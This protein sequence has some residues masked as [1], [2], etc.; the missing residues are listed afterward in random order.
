MPE[1]TE[2][3]VAANES[4]L[5]EI[6]AIAQ[7]LPGEELYVDGGPEVFSGGVWINQQLPRTAHR[8]ADEWVDNWRWLGEPGSGNQRSGITIARNPD[9]RLEAAVLNTG[10]IVWHAWQKRPDGDWSAWSSL[11]SP[12]PGAT[13]SGPTLATNKD[14]RLQLFTT[15]LRPEPA[16][17]YRTQKEPG[18]GPWEEW[19]SLGYPK[20]ERASTQAP[21]VA[22]NIDGR[23]ELFIASDTEIWHAWQKSPAGDWSSWSSLGPPGG[24]GWPVAACDKDGRLQV[25]V[26]SHT[27]TF[28]SSQHEPGRGPW[29]P[30]A[31][32]HPAPLFSEISKLA[33][34]A[35]ADGRL[36]LCALQCQSEQQSVE[37]LE[38]AHGG[39]SWPPQQA[40]NTTDIL[41]P[42]DLTIDDPALAAGGDGR[43]RLFFRVRGHTGMY[44]MKQTHPNGS[45]WLDELDNFR[46]PEGLF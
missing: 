31:P 32:V 46:S 15:S 39:W 26:A 41:G 24:G 25:L 18:Q 37:I 9:G 33:I 30:W 40:P 20:G 27:A 3:A 5:L 45:Q 10:T 35:Q 34:A 28:Y 14:G 12:V 7:P 43:L 36:V 21:T 13:L 1:I 8:D 42:D 19:H 23:L 44:F 17:W 16:V 29:E 6:V 4:G 2:F 11:D 38:Q 22:Q